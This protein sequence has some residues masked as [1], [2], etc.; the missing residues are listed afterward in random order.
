MK[1]T[2]AL[3]A[4]AVIT[5][6]AYAQLN[7]I[8]NPATSA[9]EGLVIK[10]LAGTENAGAANWEANPGLASYKFASNGTQTD[11]NTGSP[12]NAYGL[13][14]ASVSS[15]I[16]ARLSTLQTDGGILR[17][18][19]TGESAGWLNDFGYSYSGNPADPTKSFSV[20]NNI[21]A[22]ANVTFGDSFTLTF[23]KGTLNNFDLWLNGRGLEGNG[24]LSPTTDGGVYT[25][26]NQT[27]SVPY[28]APG[29][30]R[31]T[32]DALEV[33][34]W[35]T[36]TKGN[37]YADVDTYLVGVEDW[38]LK[39]G[40]DK[41]YN[42]FMFALQFFNPDGTRQE[43]PV[44]EPSTYGLIGAAGLLGLVLIRRIKSKK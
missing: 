6:S 44:P 42:D 38:N 16:N 15:A 8:P 17:V 33:N 29:N 10:H 35:L 12:D 14:W 40:A 43:L 26:F 25:V 23:G 31:L 9:P 27:N 13:H 34:T 21:Q 28:N 7:P 1:K 41:D 2:L 5:G 20:F 22:P 32:T 3:V 37:Y 19:F 36:T 18:I 4:L 39:T 30:V 11:P 24:R